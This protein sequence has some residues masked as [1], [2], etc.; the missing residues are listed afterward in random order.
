MVEDVL[1]TDGPAGDAALV[2]RFGRKHE[3]VRVG[4]ASREGHRHGSLAYADAKSVEI[5]ARDFCVEGLA[6][7]SDEARRGGSRDIDGQGV[8]VGG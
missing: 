3:D 4:N 1:G 6:D 7:R 8:G 2:S 5:H